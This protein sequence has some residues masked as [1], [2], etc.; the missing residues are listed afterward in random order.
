MLNDFADL[1]RGRMHYVSIGEGPGIVLLHGWPGFW[2]DYR[3]VLPRVASLG[4]AVAPDFFGFGDSEAV[5]GDPVAVAGEES[6]A[7]DV[8]EL[9]DALALDRVLVVGHDIGSAVAPALARLAPAR[10]H[11]LVLLNPTHPRIGEKRYSKHA[12][13]ESWYQH[14][15]VLPLAADLIDGDRGRVELYLSYF[16]EHWSG[17]A[18]IRPAELETVVDAY[19]RPGAFTSSIAWYRARAA[20]RSKQ[21]PS[22][23]IEVPTIALWGDRDPMRPLGHREGFESTFPCS[24]S[25]VLPGVGHFVAAEAPGA[26]VKAIV[27]LLR[28]EPAATCPIP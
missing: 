24:T 21:Q 10:V 20:Q 22:T 17:D 23:V 7:G 25:Y 28:L 15:H 6:L 4:H 12:Q 16:Y 13:R 8:L 27:E 26:V 18:H 2:F 3:Y 11:G 19:A 9:V 5:R 14:F 1:R